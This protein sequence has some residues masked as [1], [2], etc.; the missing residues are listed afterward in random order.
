MDETIDQFLHQLKNARGAP[1]VGSSTTAVRVRVSF[2]IGELIDEPVEVLED[3][4]GGNAGET[5]GVHCMLGFL[6]LMLVPISNADVSFSGQLI[7]AATIFV[8]V[9]GAS[10]VVFGVIKMR[11]K[12]L[13]K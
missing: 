4:R 7:G 2:V 13:P 6:G 5:V 10:L 11:I 9:F 8:W 3:L 12:G 1:H